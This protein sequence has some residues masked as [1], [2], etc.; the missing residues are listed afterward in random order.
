MNHHATSIVQGPIH[1]IQSTAQQINNVFL[2]TRLLKKKLHSVT[3][4]LQLHSDCLQILPIALSL[5]SFMV[6]NS[7]SS[8]DTL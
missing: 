3:C 2:I 4:K 1:H 5:L 7:T 8:T 6:Q